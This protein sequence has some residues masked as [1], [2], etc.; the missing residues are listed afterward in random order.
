MEGF[1]CSRLVENTAQPEAQECG[2]FEIADRSEP[3]ATSSA[4]SCSAARG[5][6]YSGSSSSSYSGSYSGSYRHRWPGS[7]S[8]CADGPAAAPDGHVDDAG[9][10]TGGGGDDDDDDDDSTGAAADR[11]GRVVGRRRHALLGLD[12]RRTQRPRPT[13]SETRERPH[14]ISSFLFDH[15][16]RNVDGDWLKS[17]TCGVRWVQ[18]LSL[19][20][21]LT[22]DRRQGAAAADLGHD[23]EVHGPETG[24]VAQDMQHRQQVE[25]PSPRRHVNR[26]SRAPH[27]SVAV[28]RGATTLLP[29]DCATSDDGC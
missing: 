26:R 25:G 17:A 10:R 23:D 28:E 4:G 19:S 5:G 15:Q 18:S 20:L 11:S 13:L 7:S 3:G 1:G 22:G 14:P 27:T 6:S 12:R 16:P 24:T 8:S 9:P 29:A 21:S 2:S